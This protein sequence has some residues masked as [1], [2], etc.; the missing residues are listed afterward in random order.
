M[1]RKSIALR[2][3]RVAR[4]SLLPRHA[5]YFTFV[6]TTLG[7][8]ADRGES[9]PEVN[10]YR[11]IAPIVVE[12]CSGCHQAGGIAPFSLETYAEAATFAASIAE[13]AAPVSGPATMP[14]FLAQE[15]DE[16]Q[17]RLGWRDDLRLNEDERAK[18]RAWSEAGAL[19]G[20]PNSEVEVN[21][22]ATVAMERE[23]LVLRIPEAIQ[24]EGNSDIHTCVV[25]DPGLTEDRYVIGRLVQSGN[26]AVLHHVVSYLVQPGQ[27]ADGTDRTKAQLEAS[28][29][30]A[31]GVGIGGRYECFGGPGLP[32]LAVD[33]L[34]AW[35][36]GGLP[37]LA[38]PGTGQPIDKDALVLLD[39]HYHPTGGVVETDSETELALM[40]AADQ[41]AMISRTILLGNFAERREF[42]PLGVGDLM[43]QADE[44]AP[45]FIIPA[46]SAAHVEEMTWQWQLPLLEPQI[47]GMGTHMHYVGRDM[48]ITLEHQTPTADQ[49]A[50]ECLVQTPA[51]DFNWQRGYVYDA[52][53]EDLPTL[54]NGD[55]IRLRC[56]YDN[57]MSNPYLV[58]ALDERGLT[59]PVDVR[60]GEDT[61]DEMCVAM[62]G[63]E[64][65][66]L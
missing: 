31:H 7:C 38:P 44:A 1:M 13:A 30:E 54:R 40:L 11:D 14:P 53:P 16:C 62:V 59:A 42:P 48:R 52:P 50:E 56:E 39:I 10:W 9:D 12:K 2:L 33:I 35:A 15:T 51:W 61:L 47:Y 58:G 41:P 66:N 55:T 26:P 25:L 46:G 17:P 20:D 5:I 34:D 57:S 18:L 28:I 3:G 19:E 60:L 36:P 8:D 27:N 22:P 45:E 4:R 63:I 24:V 37:N 29:V 23:D 32:D 6:A 65:P 49:P 21:P 64:Y 43:Q